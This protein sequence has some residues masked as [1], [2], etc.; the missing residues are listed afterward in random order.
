MTGAVVSAGALEV[1]VV[2]PLLNPDLVAVAVI[3]PVPVGFTGIVAIPAELVV[4]LVLTPAPLRA[5]VVALEAVLLD[6]TVLDWVTV[7][8]M[9][10]DEPVCTVVGFAVTARLNTG[11]A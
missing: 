8:L 4:P 6:V 10:I 9:L 11:N 3:V 1:T 2:V 7:K 5:T